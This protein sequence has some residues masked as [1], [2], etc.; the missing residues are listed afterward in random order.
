MRPICRGRRPL[1]AGALTLSLLLTGCSALLERDYSSVDPHNAAPAT[2][3]DPSI[4]RADSYQEL[5]NALIYFV[6]GGMETGTVRLYT[7]TEN[8]EPFLSGACLEVAHEDP[9]GAYC[10]EF[11]KYT[12]DPVVTYSEAKVNITYRRTREQVASIVQATGVTAIRSE[13]KS[14]LSSFAP[15][16]VLRISY[17]EEDEDFIRELVRQAYYDVPSCALGM[18]EIDLAIYPRSGRQRIVEILLDYPLERPEL[19]RRREALARE[20][21]LLARDLTAGGRQ[22]RAEDAARVLPELG[23]YDPEGGST[24][25]DLFDAVA[26]NSEGFALACA[27]LCQELD[28]P[29]R[30]AQGALDGESRFWTVVQTGEGWRH[31]DP[32]AGEELSLCTDE[33]FRDLGYLWEEGS[34]PACLSN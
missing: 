5:V 15:E 3:G 14:A 11:I 21:G 13:L 8:V 1:L 23:Q 18:P 22:P 6:N 24:P 9:L 27:A 16:R 34:L 29:C 7:D 2:E 30:V 31:L 25:Y 12:V 19:E 32:S 4:L 20:L 33:E 28:L 26:A 10:V 17:F